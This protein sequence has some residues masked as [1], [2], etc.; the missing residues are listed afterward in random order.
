MLVKTTTMP[1]QATGAAIPAN[2]KEVEKAKAMGRS[3]VLHRHLDHEFIPLERGEGKYLITEHGQKIFDGSGG[4]SVACIGWGNERVIDAVTKQLRT[5]PFC[6][7]VFF[8]T[9]VAEDLGRF[10]V[11]STKGHMARAYIV[12]SG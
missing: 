1:S 5:A 10:L 7:T 11:D 12:N 2:N 9:Q 8:T 4:P 3:A 6:A